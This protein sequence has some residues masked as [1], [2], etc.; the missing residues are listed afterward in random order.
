MKRIIFILTAV[1]LLSATTTTV[2]SQES[3]E[4]QTYSG[5]VILSVWRT[6]FI[7]EGD[8]TSYDDPGTIIE[9]RSGKISIV[10]RNFNLTLTYGMDIAKDEDGIGIMSAYDSK[11][12]KYYMKIA[13]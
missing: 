1:L 4:K 9:V 6:D 8:T 12:K 2:F 7:I 13:F 5:D 3:E 10:K 11:G